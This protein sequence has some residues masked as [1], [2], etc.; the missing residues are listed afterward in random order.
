MEGR[1]VV[2]YLQIVHK[3]LVQAGAP[4][5]G[6]QLADK[7][8]L[9]VAGLVRGRRVPRHIDARELDAVLERDAPLALQRRRR[10]VEPRH[11]FATRDL[12]EPLLDEASRFVVIEITR[13]YEHGI[14]R[15]VEA[16]EEVGNVVVRSEERRVGKG[17]RRRR[18]REHEKTTY[19]ER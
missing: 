5:R 17:G 1:D 2:R 13:E 15:R 4:A 7:R 8:H 16:V 3:A 19:D 9:G 12:A 11:I 18:E 14:V 10:H 6:K